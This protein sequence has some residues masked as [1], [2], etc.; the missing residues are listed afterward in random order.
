MAHFA[1][2]RV[3]NVLLIVATS[4][5]GCTLYGL[6]VGMGLQLGRLQL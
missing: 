5:A 1:I 3:L 2:S 4:F 6:G